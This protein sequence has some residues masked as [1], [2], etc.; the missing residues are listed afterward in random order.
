M[1]LA[2]E[3]V[4][5]FMDSR[6]PGPTFSCGREM[7]MR[8]DQVFF[9]AADFLAAAFF[10]GAAFFFAGLATA[11]S[12]PGSSGVVFAFAAA[13]FAG[14]AFFP[15]PPLRS[16]AAAMIAWHSSSVSALGSR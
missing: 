3:G 5:E 13:L 14:A 4:C 2:V 8:E 9:L 15:Q 1:T 12:F 7:W 6:G 16:G 10:F 11:P